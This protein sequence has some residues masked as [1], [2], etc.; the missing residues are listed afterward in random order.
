MVLAELKQHDK[1]VT[2]LKIAVELQPTD[3]DAHE[4]LTKSYDAL[5]QPEA[6]VQQMLVQ[7]DFDRHN[8][9]LY[10][11]IAERLKEDE[12]LSER[13]ATSLVEAAPREAEH[14]QALAEFRES[15]DRWD[16]AIDHWQH[17]ARLRS[18]EPNGLLKLAAAQVHE[19][20]WN[21]ARGTIKKL[22]QKVWPERFRSLDRD[23]QNLR[24]Q[25]P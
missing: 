19:K 10:R 1:A 14:H 3:S 5:K 22:T 7:L 25:L 18:L 9:E 16:E 13:A 24:K 21:D 11:K 2:Q 8:L 20:K 23:I 6:A 12:E 15:Q 4:A 17:V